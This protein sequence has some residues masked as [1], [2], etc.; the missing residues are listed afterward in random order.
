VDIRKIVLPLLGE[1][2]LHSAVLNLEATLD[3]GLKF[4][5]FKK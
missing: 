5:L 2:S 4:L 1:A 3:D